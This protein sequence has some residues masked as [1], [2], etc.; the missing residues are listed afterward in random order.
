MN[1]ETQQSLL[2]SRLGWVTI[3]EIEIILAYR[4]HIKI[5]EE[6]KNEQNTQIGKG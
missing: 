1:K 6:I 4:E 5:K 3:E 2:I